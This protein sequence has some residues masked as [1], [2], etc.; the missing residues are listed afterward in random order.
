MFNYPI[1]SDVNYFG[2][3]HFSLDFGEREES[4]GVEGV[5][6]GKAGSYL[7]LT[8]ISETSQI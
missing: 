4:F 2:I 8:G 6:R 7:S 1:F 3:E 5:A